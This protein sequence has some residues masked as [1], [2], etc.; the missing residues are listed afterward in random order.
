MCHVTRDLIISGRIGRMT[1]KVNCELRGIIEALKL[2]VI[3]V[4]VIIYG[5]N[6]FDGEEAYT[7]VVSV[8]HPYSV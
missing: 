5:D 2:M 1:D 7:L 4:A 3:N 6:K 8:S